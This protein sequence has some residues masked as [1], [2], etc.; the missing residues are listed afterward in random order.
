VDIAHTYI[1]DLRIELVAPTGQVVTLHNKEGGNADNLKKTYASSTHAALAG[2][3]GT[4]A[5]GNWTLRVAD[6][7]SSDVGTFNSWTLAME[8]DKA[9]SMVRVEAEPDLKIPDN[10]PAGIASV[11]R[12][13]RSGT[14]RNLKVHVD[15]DHTYIGDLRVEL[16]NP[17]GQRAL[18]HN[19]SGGQQNDL[20]TYY[21]SSSNSALAPLVGQSVNGDWTLRVSDLAGNDVGTL[22]SWS[23]EIDLA[24]R[25]QQ[26][27]KEDNNARAIPDDDAAGIGGSLNFTERGTVQ[28]LDLLVDITH[29]YIGDLRVELIAPSGKRAILHKK[30][31]GRTKDLLLQLSSG[32]SPALNELTGEPVHGDWILRVADLESLDTGTLSRWA[33]QITYIE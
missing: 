28:S 19:K 15:I 30:T 16:V 1:G 3:V 20:K 33:L 14:A 17:Q 29:S 4:K 23:L 13:A 8:L 12:V 25:S 11:L 7:A 6:L 10:D 32:A 24:A 21:E 2:L 26:V 9:D 27:R 31:C 22:N 18:L 5:A